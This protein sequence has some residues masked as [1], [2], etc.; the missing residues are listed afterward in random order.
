MNTHYEG[1]YKDSRFLL[2]LF[3]F[4]ALLSYLLSSI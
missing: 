2:A 4:G 3:L 1:L